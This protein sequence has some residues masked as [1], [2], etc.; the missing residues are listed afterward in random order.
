MTIEETKVIAPLTLAEIL[1]T[2]AE[3]GKAFAAEAQAI[4]RRIPPTTTWENMSDNIWLRKDRDEFKH[5]AALLR[6]AWRRLKDNDDP[7]LV[8][9]TVMAQYERTLERPEYMRLQ[10]LHEAVRGNQ[11]SIAKLRGGN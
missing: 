3:I 9:N 1:A 2:V 7:K 8:M 11:K 4:D 5:N 10:T 6:V